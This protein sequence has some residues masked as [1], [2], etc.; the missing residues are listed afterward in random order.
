MAPLRM[1]SMMM[2]RVVRGREYVFHPTWPASAQMS[3]SAGFTLAVMTAVG[4]AMTDVGRKKLSSTG[5][6]SALQVGVVCALEGLLGMLYLIV[7]SQLELP[8]REFWLPAVSS[9]I[10]NAIAKTLQTKAC[11]WAAGGPPLITFLSKQCDHTV[12]RM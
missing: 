11:A 7:V 6:G 10:L 3:A 5:I 12:S 8:G 2:G 9:A 1:S 4:N